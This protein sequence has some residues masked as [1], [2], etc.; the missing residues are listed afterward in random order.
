M[1]DQSTRP[2]SRPRRLLAV[3]ATVLF[4][5]ALGACGSTSKQTGAASLQTVRIGVGPFLDNQTLD[6][7]QE[8]GFPQELGLTIQSTILPSNNAIYQAIRTGNIDIGAGTLRGLQPII[9]SAPEL[10]NFMFKDQFL[11]FF[12]VGR[13]GRTPVYADLIAK[14][15]APAQAKQQVL[16]SFIGKS[17]DLIK[18]Q[19]FAP[20]ASGLR[21]AGIDPAK[22]KINDFSD[23][24]K[25]A[26]AFE[27]G[28]GDFYTGALPQQSKLLLDHPGQYVNVG[29]YEILGP[30][31]LAYD[32]WATSQHFL[33]TK[34]DVAKK[35]VAIQLRTAR[36]IRERLNQAAPKLAALVTK[37]SSTSL[38]VA[39]V[40]LL[41]SQFT[42][43]LTPADLT[44]GVFDPASP[45]FWQN[46]AKLDAVQ[47]AKDLPS[48]FRL[49]QADVEQQAFANYQ[50]DPQLVAW[51]DKPLP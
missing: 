22:V 28:Q 23:D 46:E 40:K 50:A 38:P 35:L 21:A 13:K 24:A 27:G 42:K 4:A 11:G 41:A 33:A 19:N 49:D 8:L 37:A 12:F 3:A 32:T 43:F 9:K 45:V 47:N 29:G 7:A 39:T 31:G 51:V 17:F 44:S 36:Y 14:G 6:L 2:V 5:L 1:H 10:R 20:L 30:A 16:Q 48:G 18:Q 26:L 25:A 34:P 15:V